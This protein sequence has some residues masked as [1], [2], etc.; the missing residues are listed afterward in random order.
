MRRLIV[1]PADAGFWQRP[2]RAGRESVAV[3]VLPDVDAAVAKAL[4]ERYDLARAGRDLEN[5]Q[6]T[7]RSFSTTSGC[8]TCGSRRPIAATAWPARSFFAAAVSRDRSSARATAA[9]A[10]RSARCSRNDYPTWSFG[11][12]V[13]YPIGRSLRRREPRARAQSSGS[14]P[15]SASPACASRRPRP[16]AAPGG[17]FA[18]P[19]SASR[20]RAPAHRWRRS[21]S[22]PSSGDSRSACRRRS[23]SRRRSA[24]C[25]RR[26]STC[27]RPSLDYESALVN[28]EAVQQAPPLAAGSVGRQ[29]RER[30][31]AAADAPRR[32]ASS[33]PARGSD[34]AMARAIGVVG[35]PSSIGIRP[36][37]D[38]MVR[39]LNRAP[40]VLRERG[41][42]ARLARGRFRRRRAAAVPGFRA[43]AQS[44]A[45]RTAAG[46]LFAIARRARLRRHRA[47]VV[48]ASCSAATAAS[49]WRACSAA[50]H[51][52]AR[53]GWSRLCRRACRLRHAR[54]VADGIGGGHV[55][56]AR[57]R[58]GSIR[59]WRGSPAGLRSSTPTTSRSSAAATWRSRGGHR[60]ARQASSILDLPGTQLLTGRLGEL[61][62]AALIAW[63]RTM[64]AASGSRWTPT[65]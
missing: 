9:L 36:Y 19:P 1:N 56:V 51:K 6:T 22:T 61:A 3:G 28:F 8:R 2:H 30:G 42:I 50:R 49:S 60:R 37:D 46:G 44:A 25:S 39:H 43:A 31:P 55:A 24:T 57:D 12:T 63:R 52:A 41:L 29:R 26:R 59:R 15:R 10:T 5:A 33:V 40:H 53:P 13:S 35:A 27:S 17:R 65:C 18:A 64:R 32:A 14:R 62:A 54:R 23:S 21:G 4:D 7:D 16:C 38:G 11:L 45:Q 20:R 47:S 48:S 34:R 58:T